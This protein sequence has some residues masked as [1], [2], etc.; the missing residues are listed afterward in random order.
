ME[1]EK[2]EAFNNL[3]Y[4]RRGTGTF[5]WVDMGGEGRLKIDHKCREQ[6]QARR[7]G[8]HREH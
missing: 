4:K 7:R 2:T 8:K 1:T 6:P 3:S 5:S